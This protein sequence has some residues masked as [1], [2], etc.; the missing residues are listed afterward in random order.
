MSFIIYLMIV[1]VIVNLEEVFHYT[2][3]LQMSLRGGVISREMISSYKGPAVNFVI[4]FGEG[5]A[6]HN[7]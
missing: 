1:S 6:S 3:V 2:R 7:F 5:S 4:K